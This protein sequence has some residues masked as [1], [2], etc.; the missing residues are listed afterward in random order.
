M[1]YSAN[2]DWRTTKGNVA[3]DYHWSGHDDTAAQHAQ[4]KAWIERD[5]AGAVVIGES[6]RRYNCHGFVHA[7]AHAWFEDLSPFFRDDYERFTPGTLQLNDAVVY[8]KN[9][10]ITHSGFII[11]LSGNTIIK[12]RSKWGA[13]ALVE[14]PPG[15]APAEYGSIVYY[16]RKRSPAPMVTAAVPHEAPEITSLLDAMLNSERQK[17]LWLASTVQ[18]GEEIVKSWPEFSAL[19][20][21]GAGAADAIRQ[22]LATATGDALFTLLVLAKYSGDSDLR[23]LALSRTSAHFSLSPDTGNGANAERLEYDEGAVAFVGQS[24]SMGAPQAGSWSVRADRPL[25]P[26]AQ[27]LHDE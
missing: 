15:S 24:W 16:L 12:I 6:T 2:G 19:Q 11:Q 18:V 1:P 23:T 5:F 8:V 9:G 7:F 27:V 20:L 26:D 14:H 3:S 21:H 25:H 13:A 22:R 10:S 4:I 17:H